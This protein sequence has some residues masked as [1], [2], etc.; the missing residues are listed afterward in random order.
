M[1]PHINQNPTEVEAVARAA[2]RLRVLNPG[3]AEVTDAVRDI[4]RPFPGQIEVWLMDKAAAK[5]AS[6]PGEPGF[7]AILSLDPDEVSS[8]LD[9]ALRAHLRVNGP[10]VTPISACLRVILALGNSLEEVGFVT[11]QG[12]PGLTCPG[13]VQASADPNEPDSYGA[14]LSQLLQAEVFIL[15]G[16]GFQPSDRALFSQFRR[17]PTIL[18]RDALSADLSSVLAAP[19]LPV[20]TAPDETPDAPRRV[21]LTPRERQVV[22]LL[23]R[24]RSSKELAAELAISPRTVDIY[25]SNLLTKLRARNTLQLLYLLRS[26]YPELT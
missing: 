2:Q 25:R 12:Q 8:D 21:Q 1:I 16:L 14:A 26:S 5:L 20:L 11:E 6:V 13:V 23:A 24:G 19:A 15:Y 9:E 3:I 17:R 7:D 4:L 18:L 10:I 22:T